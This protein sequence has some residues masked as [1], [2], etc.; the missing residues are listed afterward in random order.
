ML[1]LRPLSPILTNNL[2]LFIYNFSFLAEN[3]DQSSLLTKESIQLQTI[4]TE[5]VKTRE[6]KDASLK[7]SLKDRQR[8][9]NRMDTKDEQLSQAYKSSEKGESKL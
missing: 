4:K 5:P 2:A 7:T 6:T 8:S 3:T 1:S 9:P